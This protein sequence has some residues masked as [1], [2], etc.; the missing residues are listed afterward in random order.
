MNTEDAEL[1]E[2][3]RAA[4]EREFYACVDEAPAKGVGFERVARAAITAS[5]ITR[6]EEALTRYAEIID[7]AEREGFSPEIEQ[8]LMDHR[9]A[10]AQDR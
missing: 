7:R 1:V 9:A 5:G 8:E 2:R 6:V 10:L 4:I 3:V